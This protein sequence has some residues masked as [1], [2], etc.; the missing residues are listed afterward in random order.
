MPT[1]KTDTAY[2]NDFQ[3]PPPVCKYMVSLLPPGV[4]TICEPTPG[5][6]NLVRALSDYDVI[7]FTDY[8]AADKKQRFDAIVMNP[9]FSFVTISPASDVMAAPTTVQLPE[10]VIVNKEPLVPDGRLY[11]Y[12]HYFNPVD[13][14]KYPEYIAD[15]LSDGFPLPVDR[16]AR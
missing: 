2:L 8:F 4:K 5:E 15:K 12:R 7:T 10:K 6:G 16:P 13:L 11:L 14:K 9:P 1:K 3:T